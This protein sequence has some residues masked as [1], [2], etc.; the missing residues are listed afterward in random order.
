[1]L[2][3]STRESL[4]QSEH[5]IREAYVYLV[6]KWSLSCDPIPLP[7][8]ATLWLQAVRQ[9]TRER[10]SVL[11]PYTGDHNPP[12]TQDARPPHEP[13]AVGIPRRRSPDT[14]SEGVAPAT[15]LLGAEA[16]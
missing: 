13:S 9:Y 1:M 14:A 15:A 12:W 6:C 4:A 2:V 5:R 10:D 11:L 3:G 7:G 8:Q 16:H